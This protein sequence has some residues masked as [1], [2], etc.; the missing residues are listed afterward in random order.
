MDLS[1]CGEPRCQRMLGRLEESLHRLICGAHYLSVR[2]RLRGFWKADML[3]RALQL[4]VLRMQQELTPLKGLPL[5]IEA[6]RPRLQLDRLIRLS[7]EQRIGARYQIR[8][9]WQTHLGWL[10]RKV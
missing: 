1:A 2:R 8:K 6:E 7:D 5:K 4:R 10:P 3:Y 9:F